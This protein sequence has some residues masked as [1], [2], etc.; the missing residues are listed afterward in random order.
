MQS[1]IGVKGFIFINRSDNV[2]ERKKMMGVNKRE[3]GRPFYIT[4][5]PAYL[6][7]QARCADGQGTGPRAVL[8]AYRHHPLASC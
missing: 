2:L 1:G 5:L 7:L 4:S 3:R 6:H 8:P